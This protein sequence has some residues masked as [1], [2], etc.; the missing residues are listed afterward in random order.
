MIMD[1]DAIR[2]ASSIIRIPSVT[3]SEGE[4]ISF[5]DSYL[6]DAG[7]STEI[8]P[9]GS[10]I[11]IIDGGMTGPT[12]VLDGHIDTVGIGDESEWSFPP[13]AGDVA[14]GMI[15]GRGASDMKCGVAASI[16]AASRFAGQRFPGRIVVACI[17]EEE[18]FEG[19][20]SREVSERLDPD[21]VIIAESTDGRLNIGQRGR[22]EIQIESYGRSCHSS[23]PEEG[24]NAI[25]AMIE[26]I[27][28]IDSMPLHSHPLLGDGI[29]ALTDIISL[30]YPGMSVIPSRAKATYDR[31]TLPGETGDGIASEISDALSGISAKASIAYGTTT[32]YSGLTLSALRFFPAWV[33]DEDCNLVSL[34]SRGLK[35]AGLF[36]GLGH[37]SFC[38]NGSHYA[39]EKGIMTI[40]YG[41]GEERLAHTVDEAISVRSLTSCCRGLYAIL[42][43]IHRDNA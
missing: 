28:R 9:S 34:A 33:F 18:R 13:F 15:R 38:T 5:L 22:A 17:V 23:N 1:N 27:G 36:K 6:A 41:P 10:L 8:L 29:M 2:L 7:F 14:D 26:A 12:T 35:E 25:Y 20:A 16:V 30:P 40:G 31:R 21:Y 24:S 39:G 42:S 11:G 43:S 4:I 32:T 37:Y 19:I 3:G